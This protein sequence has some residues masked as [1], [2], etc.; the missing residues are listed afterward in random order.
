MLMTSIP[1]CRHSTATLTTLLLKHLHDTHAPH[2]TA[3]LGR[4]LVRTHAGNHNSRRYTSGA[5]HI[6]RSRHDNAS[7]A[8][9][10]KMFDFTVLG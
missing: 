10:D 9:L 1:A 3:T 6:L 7:I 2:S 8:S 5:Q 4:H